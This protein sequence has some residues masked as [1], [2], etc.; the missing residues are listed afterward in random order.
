VGQKRLPIY[1]TNVMMCVGDTFAVVC[2]DCIDNPAEKLQVI[3][4]L[5][6]T[7]KEIIYITEE[8]VQQFAGN[9]LEVRSYENPENKYLVM[10][11]AAYQSLTE[12]QLNQLQAHCEIIHNS[13]DT[14]EALGGGSARCMMAE[15]FLPASNTVNP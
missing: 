6:Q 12:K 11:E 2:A 9:M 3:E 14:I 15:V 7:G 10:S 13:L 8:Q 5:E 1:H 4:V